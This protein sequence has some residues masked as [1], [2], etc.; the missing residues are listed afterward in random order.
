MT[1]R[2]CRA[3]D[4]SDRRRLIV[5]P[6]WLAIQMVEREV[7]TLNVSNKREGHPV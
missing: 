2:E 4:L 3:G 1:G 5:A 6:R 7:Q